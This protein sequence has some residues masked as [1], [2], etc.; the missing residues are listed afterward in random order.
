MLKVYFTLHAVFINLRRILFIGALFFF[1]EYFKNSFRTSDSTLYNISNICRLNNWLGKLTHILYKGLYIS[2]I[3]R[4]FCHQETSYDANKYVTQIA[5]KI[6]RRHNYTCYKLC[7]PASLIQSF[8]DFFKLIYRFLFM[9]INSDNSMPCIH[10]LN[11]PC[12]LYTSP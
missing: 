11:M 8:I 1:I 10:F 4:S 2:K 6:Q 3:N 7:F 9:I 12:L 5:H